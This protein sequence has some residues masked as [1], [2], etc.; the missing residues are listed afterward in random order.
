MT[1]PTEAL[2]LADRLDEHTLGEWTVTR[3]KGLHDGQFDYAI[4]AGKHRVIAEAF[5]R[6]ARG[7][8]VAAEANARLIAAAPEMLQTIR[9]LVSRLAEVEEHLQAEVHL[10]SLNNNRAIAAEAQRDTLR[11][12]LDEALGVINWIDAWISNPVG[13]YSV[14]ALAGLF[15]QARDRIRAFLSS[16]QAGAKDV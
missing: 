5:D 2:A 7:N 12:R 9:T 8:I 13:A 14:D 4:S 6:D 11:Q 10:S 1:A 15:A 16:I 3:S